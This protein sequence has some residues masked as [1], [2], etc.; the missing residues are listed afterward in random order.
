[1]TRM[2]SLCTMNLLAQEMYLMLYPY[3]KRILRLHDRTLAA[4]H[5]EWLEKKYPPSEENILIA[6]SANDYRNILLIDDRVDPTHPWDLDI[7]AAPI[8]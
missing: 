4:K 1:M 6:R 2:S 3:K 7:L 5:E 8:Y